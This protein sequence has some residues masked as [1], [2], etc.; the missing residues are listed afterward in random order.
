M[1]LIGSGAQADVYLWGD[2]A[3]KVYKTGCSQ[4][5]IN[6]EADL[7][8]RAYR[9]G[10]PVPAIYDVTETDGRRAIIMEYAD[11]RPFGELMEAGVQS[12]ES[13]LERS[14]DIQIRIHRITAKGFPSQSGKLKSNITAAPFLDWRQ[15]ERLSG[16]LKEL[17]T[18]QQLCHGDFHVLNVLET[19]AGI[20]II[21]W[22]DASS[23]SA[24]ADVCR[25]YLLYLL[26]KE[27]IAGLYLDIYCD[28]TKQNRQDILRWLTVIAGARLN[29]KVGVPEQRKL[30]ELL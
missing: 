11:G 3:V 30:M 26:N 18:G 13:Y 9:A 1:C 14:V 21:D 19:P 20:R 5:D 29:E 2:R 25:S 15:K 17:G 24:S 4:A 28:K 7:Q 12:T 27:E 8:D 6:L 22:L 10:L 23:G 16:C